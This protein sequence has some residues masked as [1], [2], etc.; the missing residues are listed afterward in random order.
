MFLENGNIGYF[1]P[2]CLEL[3]DMEISLSQF[4]YWCLYGDTDTLVK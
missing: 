4:L 3:E 1:A 2:D